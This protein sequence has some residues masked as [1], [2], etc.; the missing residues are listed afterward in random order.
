[1]TFEVII[2]PQGRRLKIRYGTTIL[3]T[4]NES[5]VCIRSECGGKGTCGKCRVLVKDRKS[6]TP[7]TNAEIKHFGPYEIDMGYRLACC[8][9]L[10]Q[11]A[12]ITIPVESR[13]DLRK[14]Q[15]EGLEKS[16]QLNP[17]VRKVYLKLPK[18]TISDI[19]SD[20]QRLTD[21]LKKYFPDIS[22]IDYGILKTLPNA[23]R[24]S[25]FN[26]TTTVWS[27]HKL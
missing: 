4:L 14:I 27:D 22:E 2:E 16:V 9:R 21:A 17:L 20:L 3:Q 23:I 5:G 13:L 18:P 19:R 1:L 12:S 8:A 26:V 25:N 24:S 10:K 11:D 7:L 15:I 6:V